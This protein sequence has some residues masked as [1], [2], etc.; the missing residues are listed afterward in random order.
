MNKIYY[1][2][3]TMDRFITRT[4][5]L[6]A[7]LAASFSHANAQVSPTLDSRLQEKTLRLDYVFSGTDKESTIALDELAVLDGWSG[8]RVNMKEAP[9][10]GNGQVI[11]TEAATGDTLYRTA[12]STLFQEWQAT[13]E[14]TQVRKSFENVF[15]APMPNVPVNVTV[16]LYDFWD[17]VSAELTHRVDPKD[18][19]IH[20]KHSE[21]ETKYI[22]YSGDPSTCIDVAIVAEGYTSGEMDIFYKDARTAVEALFNHEPFTAFQDRFNIIAVA[23]PSA[24]SGVS[25]PQKGLWKDTAVGSHFDTFYSDRYLTTLRL[26][27]LHDLLSGVPYEHIIILA[28]TDT[29]GGGGIFNSYTLTTAHHR[30]FRPVVV[31]EFGHSFG[32]LADEYFY[33][34]Q[35]TEMYYPEIEPWEQ[36]ITTLADFGSKWLSIAKD[37]TK[38]P[39][40]KVIMGGKVI[41]EEEYSALNKGKKSSRRK[42]SE[43]GSKVGLVEGGGYQ[44]HGVWRGEENCRMRTNANPVFCDVCQAA[45]EAIIRFYTEEK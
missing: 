28:N 40:G 30:D 18:I 3:D 9:L 43:N 15:L 36:N 41:S 5:S 6:A 17:K 31:H 4:L 8:R 11:M 20:P 42:D 25:V 38:M 16:Q 23:A 24:D 29:Y 7:L 21:V 34:D 37:G 2:Y 12:F 27:K 39:D 13:E 45:L 10:R 22:H 32:G 26:K 35:Y 33:D 14:A 19:L 44:S 1:F